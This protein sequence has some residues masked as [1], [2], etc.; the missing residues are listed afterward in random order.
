[1]VK[2][3]F[4]N[5]KEKRKC[6]KINFENIHLNL[7]QKR[8]E[9]VKNSYT[10]GEL[11]NLYND[12]FLIRE[13]ENMLYSL[14]LLEK[15]NNVSYIYTG[16]AHLCIGQEAVAVGQA[17]SLTKDDYIFGSHRS[18]GELIAKGI[19]A[20]RNT[21]DSL[22]ESII[23]DHCYREQLEVVQ[24][25]FKG[26][27]YDLGLRFYLYGIMAEIF[28][29]KNGFAEGLGNSMHVFFT[30]FGIYPN[31]AIVG[32]S[33]PIAVG[34][35][36]YKRINKEKGIIIANIGDGSLGCGQVWE[37]MNFAAM[38]QYK[39]FWGY[40]GGLPILFN[41]I[42]N[43][44]GMG[45]ETN[46]ETMAYQI[47]ARV[48]AGI[49]PEQMHAESVDGYNIFAVIDAIKRKKE[50]LLNGNGPA[51]L[52]INTY[53]LGGHSTSD[54]NTNRT[55]DEI[56]AWK[57]ID[58]LKDFKDQIIENNVM[59]EN[60][61]NQKEAEIKEFLT[62]I[63]KLA[64]DD[65]IS[66]RMDL[67]EKSDSIE[68]YMFSNLKIEKMNNANPDVLCKKEDN[69]R[70]ISLAKKSRMGKNKDKI[71]S[72]KDVIQYK[73][74]IFEA[75]LDKYYK[76][77]TLISFGED[78]RDWGGA[79]GVYKDLEKSIP[80]KRLFNTPISESI[81][82]G[83]AVGYGML[84]GRCIPELMYCDFLGRAGDEVF[85]QLAKWQAMSAGK[86]KMPVV[87]R[88]SVG[89]RYGAQHSQDWSSL[90]AHVPGLKVVFPAT[91]YD[92][93]GL[94]N[95]ALIGTDP[96]IFIESQKL[97]TI[98]ELFYP[99]GVPEEYY[100]IPI[101]EPDLKIFG[102]DLTILTIGATL[103]K[104]IEAAELFKIRFGIEVEVIDAR[105]I[106]PFNYE[107]VIESVK[108]TGKI[109]I[110]SDACQ[111]GSIINDFAQNISE[112]AFDY[113]DA[114]PVVIG[115][116]NWITP[117]YE[118][119]YAFF[120]QA[121]WFLDAYHQKFSQLSGYSPIINFNTEELLRKNKF[122]I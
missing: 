15:Y 90:C 86:L 63:L 61:I 36:L 80:Y 88:M 62:F 119:E 30:P 37:S 46:G 111:R 1:M 10:N 11:I 64:I 98:S 8:M 55:K 25:G 40:D 113:L 28:G 107:V 97:Y 7:F 73:D 110:S 100:E 31:N 14:K 16:P 120:P 67:I 52:D 91:P 18:H 71:L 89:S 60:E 105:S 122:G 3:I 19:S 106:V 42:N 47:L 79:Y 112:M 21:E 95:S 104:A 81:I 20:L 39:N 50:L 82:V 13:F 34:A 53:R 114:P 108:K 74:A 92:A 35:A 32:G 41:F 68:K 58:A 109:I 51:L 49:N 44:Y 102:N 85:N 6:G 96:V 78:V 84:G 45:G 103:Y 29:R 12:M 101:G 65:N 72:S 115:S 48:G 93:K 22:I 54:A 75:I 66:P 9:D 24:K 118:L 4:I 17:F 87:L 57:K 33:A 117:T 121:E 2:E 76:D 23:E 70:I 5:P 59:T 116:R 27:I 99:E 26:N 94:M 83:A 77:S 56:S 43:G 69:P 38:D